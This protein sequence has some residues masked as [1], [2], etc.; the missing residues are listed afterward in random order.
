MTVYR[1]LP[2]STQILYPLSPA[3]VVWTLWTVPFVAWVRIW[4]PR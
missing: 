2:R 1:P 4:W 3:E